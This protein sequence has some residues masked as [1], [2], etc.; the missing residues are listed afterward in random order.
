MPY[1]LSLESAEEKSRYLKDLMDETYV[2]DIIE[3]NDIRNEKE[4]LEI[5]LDF[6][7]SAIGS[8][9]NPTKARTSAISVWWWIRVRTGHRSHSEILQQIC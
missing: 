4:T 6:V 2:R 7:S 8:L 1:L 9:T 5:L 3:R